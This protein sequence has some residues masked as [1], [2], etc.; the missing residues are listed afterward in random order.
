MDDEL[1]FIEIIVAICVAGYVAI[2]LDY[3]AHTEL[4]WSLA[5][6]RGSAILGTLLTSA[7]TLAGMGRGKNRRRS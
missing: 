3:V 7:I 1:D 2:M 6:V 5:Q 4:G